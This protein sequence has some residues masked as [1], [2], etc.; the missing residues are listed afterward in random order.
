MANFAFLD[1]AWIITTD[2]IQTIGAAMFFDQGKLDLRLALEKA[3]FLRPQD[4]FQCPDARPT[5][6]I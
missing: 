3:L 1:S 2:R 5:P 6:V 4:R